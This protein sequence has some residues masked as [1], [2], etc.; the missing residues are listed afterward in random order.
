MFGTLE[1]TG[2]LHTTLLTNEVKSMRIDF[3]QLHIVIAGIVL[4]LE[5]LHVL[6]STNDVIIRPP[7]TAR[8]GGNRSAMRSSYPS[9]SCAQA[10][11]P[12]SVNSSIRTRYRLTDEPFFMRSALEAPEA[13]I[14]SALQ[15]YLRSKYGNRLSGLRECLSSS[16]SATQSRSARGCSGEQKKLAP[17]IASVRLLPATCTRASFFR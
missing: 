10:T 16:A 8:G 17:Y 5:N 2:D 3:H 12:Q 15:V 11:A 7:V 4:P 9:V 1:A 14:A 13:A 6:T